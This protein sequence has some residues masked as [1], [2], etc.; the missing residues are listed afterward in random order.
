M[1]EAMV[2]KIQ[3]VLRGELNVDEKKDVYSAKNVIAN[4]SKDQLQDR[5]LN[6]E[7][8]IKALWASMG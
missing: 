8:C 5:D 3:E 7:I 4:Y 1:F 6:L 2:S